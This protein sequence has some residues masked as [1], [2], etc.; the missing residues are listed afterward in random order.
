M[1]LACPVQVF[2]EW[3]WEVR[4]VWGVWDRRRRVRKRA[5]RNSTSVS[6]LITLRSSAMPLR[7]VSG[8]TLRGSEE[9]RRRGRN[10]KVVRMCEARDT[11]G[12][13]TQLRHGGIGGWPLY[14]YDDPDLPTIKA[15]CIS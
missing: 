2:L 13:A 4:G 15:R 12:V 11:G 9:G 7:A 8:E 10:G 1:R 3:E 6:G 14:S 5:G